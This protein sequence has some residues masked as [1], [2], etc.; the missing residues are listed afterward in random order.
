MSYD[1]KKAVPTTNDGI[2]PIQRGETL[3]FPDKE[4][5]ADIAFDLYEQSHQYDQAQLERDAIKVRR[6]LDFI[7]LPM[8][9]RCGR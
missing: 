5:H 8:V 9:R 2:S 6:K 1:E 4:K 3:D 7:V